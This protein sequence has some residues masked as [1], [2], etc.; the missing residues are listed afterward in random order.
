[1]NEEHANI[2]GENV[3]SSISINKERADIN[4]LVPSFNIWHFSVNTVL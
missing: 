4:T 3:I 2:I 1:M